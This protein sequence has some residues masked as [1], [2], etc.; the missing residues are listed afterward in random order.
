MKK[1]KTLALILALVLLVATG[2]TTTDSSG[3]ATPSESLSES[4]PDSLNESESGTPGTSNAGTV[5]LGLGTVATSDKSLAATAEQTGTFAYNTV[6]C[7][8]AL[9][10]ND[11]IVSVKFDTLQA[12]HGFDVTGKFTTDIASPLKSNKER[13]FDYGIKDTSGI[14][15]EWFEQVGSL[16][17][18]MT[19]KKVSD[20][21]SMKLN[22]QNI[23]D[24]EELK[25]SVSIGISDQLRALE[26][27]VAD[28][29]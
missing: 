13:G 26:K 9:D 19:G 12:E 28:A 23:P 2:C 22:D 5:R 14:G 1:F 7:A 21:L 6:V 17:S 3:A 25:G 18:W 11:N 15:K 27:A 10:A 20:A 16:E 4:T 29:K 24:V 8:V